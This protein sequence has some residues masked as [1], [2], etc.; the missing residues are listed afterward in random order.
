MRVNSVFCRAL[1]A[2]LSGLLL[3]SAC[4]ALAQTPAPASPPSAVKKASPA[5]G[6]RPTWNELTPAQREALS[7]LAGMWETLGPERKRKWLEVAAKYPK[8]T[9][10]AQQRVQ[11]R[12]GEF[13]HLSPEQR[14]TARENFRRAYELPAD[15]RQEKLQRYQEL[16]E[17]KKR[18]L[19]EQAAKKQATPP[20]PPAATK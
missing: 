9:P 6:V 20:A 7:P 18:A 15:Q 3:S 16:P 5:A 8:L 10:D 19:A 11:Q 13:A 17:D 1:R 2:V 12:M 14:T 4:A